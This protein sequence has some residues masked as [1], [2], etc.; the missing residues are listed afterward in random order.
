MIEVTAHPNNLFKVRLDDE[1]MTALMAI[2]AG[3]NQTEIQ[4]VAELIRY[5]LDYMVEKFHVV[6][7]EPESNGA[8]SS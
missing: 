7:A 6:F 2:V 5:E 3:A 4:N 1:S 8:G